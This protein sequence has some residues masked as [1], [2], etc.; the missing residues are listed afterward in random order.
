[1]TTNTKNDYASNTPNTTSTT[2]NH[3]KQLQV[4]T[5]QKHKTTEHEPTQT[6]GSKQKNKQ[7]E[8]K[9]QT[10]TPET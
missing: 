4:E 6:T 5:Q 3:N 2:L 7:T 10:R 9:Q 1:M 8:H